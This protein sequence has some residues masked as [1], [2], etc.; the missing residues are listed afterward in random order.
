MLV[1]KNTKICISSNAKHKIC[2]TPNTKPEREP[3]DKSPVGHVHF[4]LFVPILFALVA[5][6]NAVSSGIWAIDLHGYRKTAPNHRS[7]ML[8][9]F[10]STNLVHT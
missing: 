7:L 4:M 6:A 1:S 5:N 3:M 8:S 9:I 10:L 2:I